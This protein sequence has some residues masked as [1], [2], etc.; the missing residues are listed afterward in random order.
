VFASEATIEA[1][2]YAYRLWAGRVRASLDARLAAL[3]ERGVAHGDVSPQNALVEGAVVHLIDFESASLDGLQVAR[4]VTTAGFGSPVASPHADRRAAAAI[5]SLLVNPL[6]P[7][8][9]LH[10]SAVDDL[11]GALAEAGHADLRRSFRS[12][13]GPELLPETEITSMLLAGIRRAATLAHEDRLF[14]GGVGMFRDPVAP[15]AIAHGAAGVIAALLAVGERPRDS[16]LDAVEERSLR[17][18]VIPGAG[19]GLHGVARLLAEERLPERPAGDDASWG[20]G[21]SRPTLSADDGGHRA[22]T[23]EQFVERFEAFVSP[24]TGPVSHLTRMPMVADGLFVYTAGQNFAVPMRGLSDLRAG[25]RSLSCGKGK[26]DIQAKASALGEAIERYSGLFHGDEPTVRARSRDLAPA[27]I[28]HPDDLHHFS[29]AQ[30]RDRDAW[31]ARPSHF[32]WVGDALDPDALIEWTPVYS[33]TERRHKLMPSSALFYA[34]RPHAEPYNASSNS[35]GCAAGSSLEDAVLQGLMELVERDATAIWWYNRLRK[36]R[37]D[38]ASFHDP[39]FDAWQERYRALGRDAWVLDLTTDLGIPTVVAV[40][41][42]VDKTAQDIV[43]ALG[44]HFDMAI[45]IGRALS[46]MNQFMA[47]VAHMPADGSG[48]YR[49]DDAVQIDF[50]E[51]ATIEDNPYL[52]PDDTLPPVRAGDHVDRSSGDLAEDVE[53]ARRIVEEAGME[54]LV[55][56]Q[57]RVDI[58]LPVVR[59]IVPGLR[60]F[61]PRNAPGRLYDV[62][63]RMG[64]LS[65]PTPES[66]LN[67]IGVFI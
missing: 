29:A 17:V 48:S 62:P 11:P 35:N 2:A 25:L 6:A 57:T 60:H 26:T 46:E 64:W 16:W 14:P 44:S 63:V 47:P 55:L 36:R 32:H 18:P 31:N 67:P 21:E 4:G 42:R 56:D 22:M 33:L 61:W 40:S 1:D 8:L 58:G 34:F 51:H 54:L 66:D 30:F 50:W 3:H 20:T 53:I 13:P 15:L 19:V 41:Y 65:E 37:V 43:F 5:S 28:V 38:L 59:V 49:F 39:Y 24:I 9:S 7:A 52:V 23:A 12:D 45:A 10:R 27:D